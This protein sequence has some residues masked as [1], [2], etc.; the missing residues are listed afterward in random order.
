LIKIFSSF[1][2]SI[3]DPFPPSPVHSLQK[4]DIFLLFKSSI[5]ENAPT[6]STQLIFLPEINAIV[7]GTGK[8]SDFAYCP[9]TNL[10]L[11]SAR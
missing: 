9:K 10:S 1:T 2:S 4:P 11:V 6:E 5:S 7:S 3:K 8:P